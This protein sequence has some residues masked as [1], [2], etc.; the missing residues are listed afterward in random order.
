MLSLLEYRGSGMK[1]FSKAITSRPGLYGGMHRFIPDYISS[2]AARPIDVPVEFY[3]R[4]YGT[5]ADDERWRTFSVLL[6]LMAVAFYIH[7]IRRPYWFAPGRLLGLFGLSVLFPSVIVFLYLLNEK[8]TGENIGT[9]PLFLLSVM[10]SV[11][12]FFSIILGGIGELILRTYHESYHRRT[13]CI[14]EIK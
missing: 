6:D 3:T 4:R 10:G 8:I 5:S 9:H 2:F 7:T 13:Y 1:G 14:R 12:G 11:F